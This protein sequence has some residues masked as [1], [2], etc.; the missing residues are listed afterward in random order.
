MI[1]Y[2]RLSYSEF[3]SSLV[4]PVIAEQPCDTVLKVD[5]YIQVVSWFSWS[6][7]LRARNSV[8]NSQS[9]SSCVHR[10]FSVGMWGH[11]RSSSD[12]WD[13]AP[14]GLAYQQCRTG[15]SSP[16]CTPVGRSMAAPSDLTV[17]LQQHQNILRRKRGTK[18]CKVFSGTVQVF[19][20]LD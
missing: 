1:H 20:I 6:E 7:I 19:N 10:C 13:M 5:E 2:M 4:P 12:L 9:Y 11:L 18:M 15:G 17:L 8:D 3:T 16:I 14:L